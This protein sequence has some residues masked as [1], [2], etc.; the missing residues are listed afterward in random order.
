MD[1]N[2]RRARR[3]YSCCLTGNQRR[4]FKTG[5]CE[6]IMFENIRDIKILETGQAWKNDVRYWKGA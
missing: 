5:G 6:A 2:T 3:K 4:P 1:L